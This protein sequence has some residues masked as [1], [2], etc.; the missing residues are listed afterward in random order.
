MK[1]QGRYRAIFITALIVTAMAL[2]SCGQQV[3]GGPGAATLPPVVEPPTQEPISTPEPSTEPSPVPTE[4]PTLEPSQ[5]SAPTGIPTAAPL[6]FSG[7]GNGQ[8]ALSGYAGN[9]AFLHATHDGISTFNVVECDAQGKKTIGIIETAGHFD[10][11]KS[12]DV[13][14]PTF[15][16]KNLCITADGNWTL[17]LYSLKDFDQLPSLSVPGQA[18]GLVS[19]VF[20]LEGDASTLIMTYTGGRVN[21]PAYVELH[22]FSDSGLSIIASLGAGDFG[23][24]AFQLL[25]GTRAIEIDADYGFWSIQVQ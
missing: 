17:A 4:A 22:A 18:M 15:R 11:T 12:M 21:M 1:T 23:G 20:H 8:V 2:T 10:G 6:E 13:V 16:A 9:G 19:Q 25:P 3:G 14:N 24:R 7:K 5:T